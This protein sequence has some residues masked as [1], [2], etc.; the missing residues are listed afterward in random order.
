MYTDLYS[1]PFGLP[2]Q[3]PSSS[4][5]ESSPIDEFA[6]LDPSDPALAQFSAIFERFQLPEAG[7]EVRIDPS[8]TLL[9]ARRIVRAE[10]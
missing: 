6:N 7:A 2:S 1:F 4:V 3:T 10:G 9:V 8:F 5:K